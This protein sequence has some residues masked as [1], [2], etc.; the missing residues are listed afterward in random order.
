[1]YNRTSTYNRNLRVSSIF[2]LVFIHI[3]FELFMSVVKI[4]IDLDKPIKS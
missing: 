2:F 1:M 3:H 4:R